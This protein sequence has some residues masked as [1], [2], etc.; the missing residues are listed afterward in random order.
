M[1]EEHERPELFA[2]GEPHRSRNFAANEQPSISSQADFPYQDWRHQIARYHRCLGAM[3]KDVLQTQLPYQVPTTDP[4]N[5]GNTHSN[6]ISEPP[7]S[8]GLVTLQR[9]RAGQVAR[10]TCRVINAMV[11]P[12]SNVGP[13]TQSIGREDDFG[14]E[15]I[16][17]QR[18]F[19]GF[20]PLHPCP[21]GESHYGGHQQHILRHTSPQRPLSL[22]PPPDRMPRT[23][24]ATGNPSSSGLSNSYRRI[25][26][27]K[28]PAIHLVEPQQE[29]TSAVVMN[30]RSDRAHHLELHYGEQIPPP[31]SS[32]PPSLPPA[33]LGAGQPPLTDSQPTPIRATLLNPRSQTIQFENMQP[34]NCEVLDDEIR[35]PET[36]GDIS[37]SL[38]EHSAVAAV[39]VDTAKSGPDE[40]SQF[41]TVWHDFFIAART[42]EFEDITDAY[43]ELLESAGSACGKSG[44]TDELRL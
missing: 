37:G 36:S 29:W 34:M 28:L 33:K 25:L 38:H 20:K 17:E 8:E 11:Y 43:K 2:P 23:Y 42:W 35:Q 7:R 16:S 14:A 39:V 3:H 9:S 21:P 24:K 5:T 31:G 10:R 30:H 26:S 4:M 19:V 15:D 27:P 44:M 1:P 41:S 32:H 6:H 22:A 12:G 18:S 13:P 40:H